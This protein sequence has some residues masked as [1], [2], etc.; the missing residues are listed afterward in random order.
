MHTYPPKN[1]KLFL[2]LYKVC[3]RKVS[4]YGTKYVKHGTLKTIQNAIK[5]IQDFTNFRLEQAPPSKESIT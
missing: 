4:W 2:I 3:Q 5:S 1:V